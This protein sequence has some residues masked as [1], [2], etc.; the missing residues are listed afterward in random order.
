MIE[1]QI[2]TALK[3]LVDN[4][5]YR[6]IAPDNVT[7]LPRITFQAIGG[8]SINYLDSATIPNK[9]RQR[10]QINVWHSTRDEANALA[11]EVEDT[12]RAATE[13]QTTVL[14]GFV[15]VYEPDTRLYGTIQDFTVF[16]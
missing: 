6:D 16:G 8:Q 9:R 15:S 11:R 7:A 1:R 10:V 12:M 2:Y 4:K 14:G 5:V 3:D 13:L